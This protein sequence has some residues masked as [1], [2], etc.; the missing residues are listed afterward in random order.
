M[1]ETETARMEELVIKELRKSH[2]KED[3]NGYFVEEIYADYR[4][5]MDGQTAGRIIDSDDPEMTFWEELL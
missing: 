4:D 3:G 1:T 5:E 2:L